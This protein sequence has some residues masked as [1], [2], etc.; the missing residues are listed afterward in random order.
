MKKICM[1]IRFVLITKVLMLNISVFCVGQDA[2]SKMQKT[3]LKN[4]SKAKAPKAKINFIANGHSVSLPENQ[5]QCMVVGMGNNYGQLVLSGAN[6]FTVVYVGTIKIGQIDIFETAG[7]PNLGVSYTENG[8]T[9]YN[10]R[11]KD[12]KIEITKMSP[13]GNNFYVSGKFNGVLTSREGNKTLKIDNGIF[14][15]AYVK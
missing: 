8:I 5:S 13:E 15:S 10:K 6:K 11:A 14:E 12:L 2:A 3:G 7:M 1:F 4:A 9:Y